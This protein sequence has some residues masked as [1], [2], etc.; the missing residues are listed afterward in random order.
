M[1]YTCIK[2][3][4]ETDCGAACLSTICK[5]Y[6]KELNLS[7]IRELAQVDKHGVNML[8]LYKAAQKL[9]F[10]AKGMHGT[11]D[12]L[13]TLESKTPFIA[14]VLIN[15]ILEHYI[16]VYEINEKKIVVAD[17]ARGIVT[18]SHKDFFDIWKGYILTLEPNENFKKEKSMQKPLLSYF[19]LI[20]QHKKMF[21]SVSITSL[22]ITILSIYATYYFQFLIDD[23]LPS[24][25]I[26]KLIFISTTFIAVYLFILAFNYVRNRILAL[27]TKRLNLSIM[28]DYIKH[29]I[30]L[31]MSFYSKRTVGDIISRFS[32]ADNIREALSSVTLTVMLD[33]VLMIIG[34]VVLFNNNIKLFLITC[35]I[36]L[37]Y[38]SSVA[39]FNKPIKNVTQELREHD[40]ETT[41]NLIETVEGIEITKS[42]CSE[43]KSEEKNIFLIN[44]L[45]HTSFR[46][47]MTFANQ[48]NISDTI[49]SI[50]QVLLLCVGGLDVISGRMSTGTLMTFY[51]MFSLFISPIKNIVD[52]QPTIQKASVSAQRLYDVLMI[53]KENDTIKRTSDFKINQTI[54]FE[55]VSFQYGE[56]KPV[57]KNLN[58]SIEQGEKVGIVGNSGSGKSTLIKLLLKFYSPTEGKIFIGDKDIDDIDYTDVRNRIAYVPQKVFLFRGTIMEN[59]KY[60]SYNMTDDDI[61]N[62]C[63]KLDLEKFVLEF[64][65]GYDT[66]LTEKGDNLS[67]GQKQIISI[68]RALIADK[69]ILLLDEA[70]SNMDSV[71]EQVIDT[72]IKNVYSKKT[73]VV[74]AHRLSTIKKCDKIILLKDGEIIGI[75]NHTRLL[76]ENEY[77]K[78]LWEKQT[79]D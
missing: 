1:S 20:V 43:Q 38:A 52:L 6:G 35:I 56:R 49:V 5:H 44:K 21:L 51:A 61:K 26:K 28:T 73:V 25:N 17:P 47:T 23:I 60:G 54:K 11:K 66:I 12:E 50:G 70:T 8:G 7:Y 3:I 72:T 75:D 19:K 40:S 2:Q 67:G 10:S 14:H 4:D 64:P 24:S 65:F 46:A 9:G 45:M 58:F 57:L 39:L 68:I 42:Y 71:T 76:N 33:A 32:D 53:P 48:I 22:F 29:L 27:L 78:K 77:Y 62:K 69:D 16:V 34:G 55:D 36:M 74:I 79:I 30:N 18:Y 63:Q 41:A 59:L 37:I 15:E 13:L 31:P